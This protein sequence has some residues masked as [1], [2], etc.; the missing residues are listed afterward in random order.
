MDDKIFKTWWA[1]NSAALGCTEEEAR[2]IWKA[3]L[4]S[5]SKPGFKF[6]RNHIGGSE[7]ALYEC[8]ACGNSTWREKGK[9]G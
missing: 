1:V 2:V 5:V 4:A 8:L 6:I 7:M 9:E 3:A